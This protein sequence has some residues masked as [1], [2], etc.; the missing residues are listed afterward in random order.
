MVF[1]ICYGYYLSQPDLGAH[2]PSVTGGQSKPACDDDESGMTRSYRLMS[3]RDWEEPVAAGWPMSRYGSRG[4]WKFNTSP[5]LL[6][7]AASGL[8]Q[9]LNGR[10]GGVSRPSTTIVGLRSMTYLV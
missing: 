10:R 9:Y 1:D 4:I 6:E 8:N 5:Y 3:L 2:L 7:T